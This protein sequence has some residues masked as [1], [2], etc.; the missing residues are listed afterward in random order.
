MITW[1]ALMVE[2]SA[3][4]ADVIK[5][6]RGL[7]FQKVHSR[8]AALK[9]MSI[10]ADHYKLYP[11]TPYDTKYKEIMNVP[12]WVFIGAGT[13]FGYPKFTS[14]EYIEWKEDM[15]RNLLNWISRF[16]PENMEGFDLNYD[17]EASMEHY[18]KKFKPTYSPYNVQFYEF[19]EKVVNLPS[20]KLK[21][22][23]ATHETRLLIR[24][25]ENY[26][27]KQDGKGACVMQDFFNWCKSFFK[28]ASDG[29]AM[30]MKIDLDK[31]SLI[32]GLEVAEDDK[33]KAEKDKKLL[34][35]AQQSTDYS[36]NT[37]KQPRKK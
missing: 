9:I 17:F 15:L 24:N 25:E 21:K 22:F 18:L 10:A 2:G 1:F 32:P 36:A 35:E 34:E 28:F 29:S 6:L 31:L 20:K 4:E 33:E 37:P 8:D 3:W 14:K 7:E 13:I 27:A 16:E 12:Y 26:F 11:D 5:M 30:Q 19:I 23:K